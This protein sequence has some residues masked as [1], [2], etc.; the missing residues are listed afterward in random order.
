MVCLFGYL[1]SGGRFGG[2][3]RITLAEDR[4]AES[5]IGK[6]VA[7]C[8]TI[9]RRSKLKFKFYPVGTS[10]DDVTHDEEVHLLHRNGVIKE[11]MWNGELTQPTLDFDEPA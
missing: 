6:T 2:Y 8:Q 4:L 9:L 10:P 5:C 1:Y 3:R 7:D 11:V